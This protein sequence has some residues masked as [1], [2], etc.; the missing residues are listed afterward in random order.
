MT[1]GAVIPP[2]IPGGHVTPRRRCVRHEER[3]AVGRCVV[4]KGGFCRECLTEHEDRLYC[5]PCFAV[6]VEAGRRDGARRL[7]WRRWRTALLM[8]GSLL[9]LVTGIYL[10]GRMLAAIP[11]DVH[12]G[13]VWTETFKP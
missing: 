3:E 6:R 12:D 11:A 1:N 10:L 8:T 13:T 7:D 9:C 5:G 2:V 4:C